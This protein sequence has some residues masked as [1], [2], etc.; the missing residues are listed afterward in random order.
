MGQK[1][2]LQLS[3]LMKMAWQFIKRNGYSK[4]EALKVAW[5]NFKLKAA[6]KKGI[7]KFYFIKV[8]GSIREAFG[9]LKSSLVPPT[10]G[11]RRE[12]PTTQTYYDTEKQAWRSFKIANLYK[13]A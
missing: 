1:A 12:C 4:S 13:I 6:L 2:R 9:T 10:Q 8:D 3:D 5:L 7:V 11:N